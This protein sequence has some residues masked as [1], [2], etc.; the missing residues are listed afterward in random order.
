MISPDGAWLAY[1]SNASGR[2][3]VYATPFPDG[4][5]TVQISFGGGLEP[6]WS[7]EGRELFYRSGDSVMAVEAPPTGGA[8]FGRAELLFLVSFSGRLG[9]GSPNYDVAQGGDRFLMAR[10]GQSSFAWTSY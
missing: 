10:E 4:G 5:R 8:D 2:F 9:F 6:L 1:T 3:E 7:R